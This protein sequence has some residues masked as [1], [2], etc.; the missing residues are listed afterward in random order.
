MLCEYVC[1]CLSADGRFFPVLVCSLPANHRFIVSRIVVNNK[2]CLRH[3]PNQ[4]HL[5]ITA[6]RTIAN[7]SGN[8]PHRLEKRTQTTNENYVILRLPTS[9]WFGNRSPSF[10]VLCA[11]KPLC[12][13]V[14]LTACMHNCSSHSIPMKSRYVLVCA[15]LF[16]RRNAKTSRYNSVIALRSYNILISLYIPAR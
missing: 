4:I 16:E 9:I 8:G 3:I 7:G 12:L 1:V 10:P 11:S 2:I 15:K 13:P 6:T 5:L 14:C